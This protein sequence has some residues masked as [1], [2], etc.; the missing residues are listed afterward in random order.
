MASHIEMEMNSCLTEMEK[1]QAKIMELQKEKE[2]M[3]QQ[4]QKRLEKQ[5]EEKKTNE[6]EPNLG[7]MEKWLDTYY[8]NEEQ[9]KLA[10]VA[11]DNWRDMNRRRSDPYYAN[12]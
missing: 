6:V 7:V 12:T 11:M 10:K 3:E 8:E 5:K 4:K 9:K 2:L 1:L